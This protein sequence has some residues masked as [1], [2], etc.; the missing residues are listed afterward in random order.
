MPTL[1]FKLKEHFHGK[2]P[3]A[4]SLNDSNSVTDYV[5]ISVQ[6][7]IYYLSNHK[8]YWRLLKVLV[9]FE[10]AQKTTTS[11]DIEN[12][13]DFKLG[14]RNPGLGIKIRRIPG[15]T[16]GLTGVHNT[17]TKLK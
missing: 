7:F 16:E 5:E 6:V 8:N 11:K 12:P 14:S 2:F 10:E 9:Y 13:Y 1:I 4:C 17:L 15:K 3:T